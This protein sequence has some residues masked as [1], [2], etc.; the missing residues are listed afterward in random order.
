MSGDH[1]HGPWRR[2]PPGVW[3]SASALVCCAALGPL[4]AHA[5]G[6]DEPNAFVMRTRAAP[7]RAPWR[8]PFVTLPEVPASTAS[9]G[10]AGKA[11]ASA[12]APGD[13]VASA[14]SRAS[15]RCPQRGVHLTARVSHAHA[16]NDKPSVP[17]MCEADTPPGG[18]AGE[19][20]EP[21]APRLLDDKRYNETLAT[22]PL[23]QLP[24][25]QQYV[26]FRKLGGKARNILELQLFNRHAG[27][28]AGRAGEHTHGQLRDVRIAA[29]QVEG[30]RV[31]AEELRVT[32]RE[33]VR[34]KADPLLETALGG[35]RLAGGAAI[36][37]SLEGSRGLILCT[38]WDG[39]DGSYE[40]VCALGEGDRDALLRGELML[41]ARL[42]YVRYGHFVDGPRV[43]NGTVNGFEMSSTL[44]VHPLAHSLLSSCVV[45]EEG[46]DP[47][48]EE[49]L[50]RERPEG[51]SSGGGGEGG[52]K[53]KSG[54]NLAARLTET[55]T[56]V[57]GEFNSHTPPGPAPQGVRPC[58]FAD[59]TTRRGGWSERHRATGYAPS[60]GGFGGPPFGF[61]GCFLP[62]ARAMPPDGRRAD[63]MMR[64]C[65]FGPGAA[66]VDT[67]GEAPAPKRSISFYCASHCA[68]MYDAIKW[69]APANKLKFIQGVEDNTP[70]LGMVFRAAQFAANMRYYVRDLVAGRAG[71]LPDVLVLMNGAWDLTFCS[72]DTYMRKQLPI[73]LDE[74]ARAH[75]LL[76]SVGKKVIVMTTPSFPS[77]TFEHSDGMRGRKN[78]HSM[79]AVNEVVVT[80]LREWGV[81]VIDYAA[82]TDPRNDEASDIA[83]HFIQ[84]WRDEQFEPRHFIGGV[85]AAGLHTLLTAL[86]DGT[87]AWEVTSEPFTTDGEAVGYLGDRSTAL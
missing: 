59:V 3:R 39:A 20:G 83:G 11:S 5:G 1:R 30:V 35:Q 66:P 78:E 56:L 24:A 58:T 40:A 54:S 86:C 87:G 48:P 51:G 32:L 70:E 61:D 29:Y 69:L 75:N 72:L 71:E 55:S 63:P 2:L 52:S 26:R 21:A 47:S 82:I 15:L 42:D 18:G 57:P 34:D 10:G 84:V 37:V 14:L 8:A 77:I 31:G 6:R 4:C 65:L 45:E 25:M 23:E 68:F 62:T 46:G 9:A 74:Y 79:R 73:V 43:S 64:A 13:S 7:P 19:G 17:G 80:T 50:R 60:E 38:L 49:V 28:Q 85:G 76:T 41:E 22:L 44:V 36:R 16:L 67:D 81:P 53:E 33:S 12:F 27:R